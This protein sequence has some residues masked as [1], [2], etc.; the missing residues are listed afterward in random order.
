MIQS[1]NNDKD[2]FGYYFVDEFKTYSKVEAVE[3]ADRVRK[4]AK[5]NFNDQVFSSYDWSLEPQESL[6]DLYTRRAQEIRDKYDYV[7]IF[8][9]G[10]ID[11]QNIVDTFVKNGIKFEELATMNYYGVEPDPDAHFHAEHTYVT[12]PKIKELQDRGIEF[13][14][15]SIDLSEFSYSIL[16]D[17][18]WD[19]ER[20]YHGNT[21]ASTMHVAKTYIREKTED[22]MKIIESGKRL[23]FVWGADKPRV[24]VRDGKYMIEFTDYV[25]SA[26]GTRT[27]IVNREWE[28]DELFYWDP[29]C[30]DLICKQAHVIKKFGESLPEPSRKNFFN[31]SLSEDLIDDDV[32]LEVL[33]Q[34][35]IHG[36]QIYRNVVHWLIYPNFRFDM[37]STGKPPSTLYNVYS[38]RDAAWFKDIVLRKQTDLLAQ[39]YQGIGKHWLRDPN[40][41]HGGIKNFFTRFEICP[42]DPKT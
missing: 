24:R 10:G 1:Y 33:K 7:V 28:H 17:P 32:L 35:G 15:R 39:H 11:S 42:V 5:W 18:K 14:H 40:V 13:Q 41:P 20:A 4:L 37:F 23:V 29:S 36:P 16:T 19:F 34:N 3:Y 8:Y 38:P 2:R 6:D 30:C 25:G 21:H 22:Y 12:Y 31:R 9:S 26:I 27:Q